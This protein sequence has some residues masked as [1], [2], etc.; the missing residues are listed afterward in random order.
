MMIFPLNSSDI[1]SPD[2]KHR[3]SLFFLCVL[4]S[5]WLHLM[6]FSLWQMWA[7]EG[8]SDAFYFQ[9]EPQLP[10]IE[11]TISVGEEVIVEDGA[12]G[13]QGPLVDLDFLKT[14]AQNPRPGAQN[15]AS[16]EA[17]QPSG[18]EPSFPIDNQALPLGP[19]ASDLPLKMEMEAPLLKSYYTAIRS[20]VARHWIMPPEAKNQF[21]PGRLTV[22]FTIRQDG[23]LIKM[24]V[25]ESSGSATLDHAGL[26]ALRSAAPFSVFP[27][28]L[29]IYSQLD[30][31]MNF[32]YQAHY[33]KR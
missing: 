26:E 12:D 21:R 16:L 32:D 15:Q 14:E 23:A 28:D 30:I 11:L 7:R 1:L 31:R 29:N 25:L 3:A 22:D 2:F 24:V 6:F 17:P 18:A 20:A 4:I 8:S 10:V 9:L 19:P 13:G 33:V 5:V 27:D